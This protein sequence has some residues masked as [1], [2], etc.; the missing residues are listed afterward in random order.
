MTEMTVFPVPDKSVTPVITVIS[1][2]ERKNDGNTRE[3]QSVSVA[4]MDNVLPHY[5]QGVPCNPITERKEFI[6]EKEK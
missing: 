2:V 4:S 6:F 1:Q 5:P 3:T